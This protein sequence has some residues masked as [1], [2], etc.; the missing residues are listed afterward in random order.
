MFRESDSGLSASDV[1]SET[2]VRMSWTVYQTIKEVNVITYPEFVGYAIIIP[3][4]LPHMKPEEQ[5]LNGRISKGRVMT[6]YRKPMHVWGSYSKINQRS[7]P[8]GSTAVDPAIKR[9]IGE[10]NWTKLQ[11]V[12]RTHMSTVE[13]VKPII[14]MPGSDHSPFSLLLQYPFAWMLNI[15]FV[16]CVT[17]T[18]PKQFRLHSAR[19]GKKTSSRIPHRLELTYWG[20]LEDGLQ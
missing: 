1:R 11:T 13:A 17:K 2:S 15:I 8:R 14:C 16:F 3:C 5:A 4:S 10:D 19:G 9:L 6:S 18:S 7:S 12:H 20:R